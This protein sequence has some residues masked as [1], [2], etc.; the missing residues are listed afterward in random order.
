MFKTN[1]YLKIYSIIYTVILTLFSCSDRVDKEGSTL[2][3]QNSLANSYIELADSFEEREELDSTIYYME[4][5]LSLLNESNSSSAKI[6]EVI[7]SLGGHYWV[8][9]DCT[10]S[11]QLF[12]EAV[13]FAKKSEDRVLLAKVWM[14]LA[15]NYSSVGRYKEAISLSLEALSIKEESGNSTNI[16]FDYLTLASIFEEIGDEDKW[17]EY[18]NR[19]YSYKDI[20]NGVTVEDLTTL[21]NSF[22]SICQFRKEYQRSLAYHDTIRDI[23]T[24]AGYSQGVGLSHLNSALIYIELEEFNTALDNIAIAE[25]YLAHVDYYLIAI[26]ISKSITQ[27]RLGLYGEALSSINRAYA[28][29]ELKL[30]PELKRDA[31]QQL[32]NISFKL[33]DYTTAKVWIDSLE[34]AYIKHYNADRMNIV[35]ELEVKYSVEKREL[36][37][38]NLKEKD[39]IKTL[40]LTLLYLILALSISSIGVVIWIYR[41][42]LKYNRELNTLS[43]YKLL[44]SQINTHFMYNVLGSIQNFMLRNNPKQAA[45]YLNNYSRLTRSVLESVEDDIRPLSDEIDLIE[46]YLELEKMRL[47]KKL[48]YDIN[49]SDN[50]DIE[51]I[52]IPTLMLQPIIENSIKHGFKD[53]YYPGNIT[54]DIVENEK[55]EI[56]SEEDYR[57]KGVTITIK[58]NGI[59]INSSSI[60]MQDH[61]SMAMDIM[62]S[63]CKLYKNNR[64]FSID[65][66]ISDLNDINREQHGT[67]T[68]ITIR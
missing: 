37:I 20:D 6:A 15:G 64:C 55:I 33:K 23:S 4:A 2:S 51:F 28:N 27:E 24:D 14:N 34:A 45:Q 38:T 1:C 40:Q 62:E 47:G 63:R 46:N 30:Y 10:K 8:A 66:N 17:E 19:A 61:K 67:I 60:N 13:P 59:G 9:G 54:I 22:A 32:S 49:Y 57:C 65:Y 39:K 11:T 3:K 68:T 36:E 48:T 44:H 5:A 58:D 50:L 41:K 43:K 7:N 18:A 16:C 53:I 21:Y 42:R 25:E 12:E 35:K 29:R 56:E 26:L 52:T 31:I